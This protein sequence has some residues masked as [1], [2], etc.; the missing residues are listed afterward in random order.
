MTTLTTAPFSLTVGTLIQARVTAGNSIDEGSASPLNVAGALAQTVPPAP[1]ASPQLVSQS[2][3]SIS[4]S[5][6]TP[7]STGGS[8]ITSY[9]LAFNGGG[10]STTY[11]SL[12]GEAP[13]SLLQSYTKTGLT[14]N[15]SY[16]FKYRV[17]NKHGWSLYSPEITILAAELPA[18]VATPTFT[19]QGLTSVRIAW[20]AP[21]NGGNPI[22]AY[23]I[24]IRQNDDSTFSAET[25]YCDG[26]SPTVVSNRYCDIPFATLRA[27]PFSLE[28]DDLVI[29]RVSATNSIGP[30]PYS[31]DNVSGVTIQTEPQAPPS[32]PAA[33]SFDESSATIT[34]SP[35]VGS[36]AGSSSILYYDLTWDSGTAGATFTSYTVTASITVSVTG[37]TS[38]TDY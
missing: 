18:Q 19:I 2:K 5:M 33:S 13:D 15:E 31:I 32:P 11:V 38:G 6:P 29:A 36:Q 34:M 1:S 3:T 30:G 12:I 24:L 14:A 17:M 20:A 23:S 10:A 7:G 27:A 37:L 22:I 8:A 25:S 21:D 16:K 9:N 26:S 4:V 35:L 28:L